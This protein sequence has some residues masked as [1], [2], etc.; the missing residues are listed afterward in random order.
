MKT[1]LIDTST[2]EAQIALVEDNLVQYHKV[3]PNDPTIGTQLLQEIDTL[4]TTHVISMQ[5][6][7][8]I[9]AHTGPRRDSKPLHFA[10]LRTGI[11]TA[12]MLASEN[13]KELVGITGDTLEELLSKLEHAEPT[14][15]LTP[16]YE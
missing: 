6:I 5:D 12:T 13:A 4:F 14:K 11:V 8:R 15:L 7:D 1:L 9:A 2:K 10:A 16:Q 3:W